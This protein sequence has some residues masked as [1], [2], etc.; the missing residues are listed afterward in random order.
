MRRLLPL[1][2]LSGLLSATTAVPSIAAGRLRSAPPLIDLQVID[3]EDGRVLPR[4][5]HH[6]QAWL[7]GEPGHRYAVRLRNAGAQ[8]VL[9][10]LSVDG[11]NAVSGQTADPRQAGYVLGPWQTLEVAGW[12]KSLD[13]VAQFVFVD[14]AES[15]AAR[16]GR[17][18]NLGVIGIAV[19]RERSV[20]EPQAG[21][22]DAWSGAE[23]EAPRRT[24]APAAP[25]ASA[26]PAADAASRHEPAPALG[27]GHG[28]IEGA[29]AYATTFDRQSRPAQITQLRYDTRQALLA[30]GIALPPTVPYGWR[31]PPQAFPSGFVPDPPCCTGR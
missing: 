1:L 26:R 21:I 20:P 23:T 12:R 15:Y 7:P 19:Y 30:R 10:V 3:R 14:P 9:V 2:L 29:P 6:G 24:A 4:Y 22:A 31:D 25:R 18:D 28:R 27:T 13:A 5:P 16:T 17:P 11:I 8:R